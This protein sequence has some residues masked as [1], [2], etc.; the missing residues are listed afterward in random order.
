MALAPLTNIATALKQDPDF[1]KMLK[2]ISIMGGNTQ[3]NGTCLFN[4]TMLNLIWI[5]VSTNFNRYILTGSCL[6]L[7]HGL[8]MN[9]VLHKY[10]LQVIILKYTVVKDG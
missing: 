2:R 8:C 4:V 5:T 3:G 10:L 1:G 7:V 9:L 6:K